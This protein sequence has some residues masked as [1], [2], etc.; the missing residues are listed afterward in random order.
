MA[1]SEAASSSIIEEQLVITGVASIAEGI[2]TSTEGSATVR[3]DTF[4]T[5]VTPLESLTSQAF[6]L[7]TSAHAYVA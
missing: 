1:E 4:V 3:E 7:M 5:A 6:V 2:V